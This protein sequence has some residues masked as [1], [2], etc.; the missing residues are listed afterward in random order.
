M[1]KSR[2]H[3]ILI[4]A[5]L[6]AGIASVSAQTVPPKSDEGKLIAVVPGHAAEAVVAAMR[7]CDEGREA[8]VIGRV[9][10]DHPGLVAMTTGLGAERI[11]DMPVGEQLPRIC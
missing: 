9:V 2:I 11:V 6:L 7:G 10:A 5:L 1:F 3:A 4:V 8:V